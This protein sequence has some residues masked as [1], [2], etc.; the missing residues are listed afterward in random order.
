MKSMRRAALVMA[1]FGLAA[2]AA[3][4]A[5]AGAET[6]KPDTFREAGQAAA[7]V[8]TTA[9]QAAAAACGLSIGAV[10][11]WTGTASGYDV[12]ATNPLTV[13][14][15]ESYKLFG[16]RAS[17]SWYYTEDADESYFSGL[18]LQNSNLYSVD[19]AYDGV[20][21]EPK[22]SA[23]KVGTGWSGF[24]KIVLSNY[25]QGTKPHSYLYGLHSNGSLYRYT[26]TSAGIRNWGS[27][28]GFGSVKNVTLIAETA[29]YD[30]LLVSTF[31]GSLY[32]VRVPLT[33]PMKPVVKKVRS[34]GWVKYQALIA[35]RCGATSTLLAAIDYNARTVSLF[36]VSRATGESTIIKGLGTAAVPADSVES[37]VQF[38]LT[39]SGGPQLVGE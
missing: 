8:P 30:T 17:T 12:T 24:G 35:Q 9:A 25:V 26:M 15:L 19:V 38:L 3:V 13:S 18:I 14:P 37:Y 22:V 7:K 4:P 21:P 32:T 16:V 2:A 28:P 36:A 31:G 11:W 39:G 23:V 6:P 34:T 27:A 20:A 33:A 10:N 5:T 29:T 1:A